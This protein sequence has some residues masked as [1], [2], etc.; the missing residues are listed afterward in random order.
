MDGIFTQLAKVLSKLFSAQRLDKKPTSQ[1]IRTADDS[2]VR[3]LFSSF[4]F[5]Q[6]ISLLWLTYTQVSNDLFLFCF[7]GLIFSG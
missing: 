2:M 5:A 6:P 3:Y 4:R 7:S 1:L